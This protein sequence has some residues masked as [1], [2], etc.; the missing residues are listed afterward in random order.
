MNS[1]LGKHAVE[2]DGAIEFR[3]NQPRSTPELAAWL[4]AEGNVAAIKAGFPIVDP[5]HHLFGA[6]TDRLFYRM[7]DLL[8]DAD[9]GHRIIGTVYVEAYES[10]WRTNGPDA[11]RPVGEVEWVAGLT[12]APLPLQA[13]PCQVAAGIVSHAD[14][15]LGDAV[16]E[17][18]DAEMAASDGRLRGVRHRTATVDGAIGRMTPN[19]R[20]PLL[21]A[22]PGFR[23]GFRHLKRLGLS[24]DS[25]VYHPQINE[26]VSLADEFPECRIVVN[27]MAG[28]IGVA[29]FRARRTDVLREWASGMQALARRANVVMKIGGL[30]MPLLGLGFEHDPTPPTGALLAKAW[31]PYIETCVDAFGTSRCMF[32]SNFPVDKQSSSYCALWN[33]F[34]LVTIGWSQEECCDLFYRTACRT[35]RLPELESYA[36]TILAAGQ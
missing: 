9:C 25:W 22:D 34:K 27:H 29:E 6:P 31:R 17:V 14:L 24:F 19:A 12:A 36:Q 30:G 33:A 28:P 7:E 26:L 10:G 2:M 8:A 32:E 23:R 21:L 16:E 18:L 11:L 1:S 4:A 20:K 13:G 5:H 15:S 3:G 35:Y